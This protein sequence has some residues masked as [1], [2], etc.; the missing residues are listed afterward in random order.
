VQEIRDWLREQSTLTLATVGP[1]GEPA[2]AD[3]YFAADEDLRVYFI[4]EQ[5]SRHVAHI[6]HGAKV[7]ATVH[8][9][10]WDWR[11]IRGLQLEGLC[12]PLL[13]VHERTAALALYGRKFTFLHTFAAILPR[14]TL[15]VIAPRWIRWLDNSV[16]FGHQREWIS[17]DGRWI[18][19]EERS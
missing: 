3:L 14:H 10:A 13:S 4:S 18:G 1:E 17:E 8:A 6:G 7:A 5:G 19:Q 16:G 2:A 12:R 11:E 15:F 9:Q